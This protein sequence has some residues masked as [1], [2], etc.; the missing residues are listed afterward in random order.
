M[1]VYIASDHGG[2]ELKKFLIDELKRL[3]YSIDDLGPGNYDP[4]DDYPEYA[5]KV[6]EAVSTEQNSKMGIVLCRNGVG[7]CMVANKFKGVKCALSWNPEHIKSA[8]N[9]DNANVLAL[10]ADYIDNEA[11]LQIALAFLETP[12]SNEERHV[13][14]LKQVDDYDNTGNF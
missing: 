3:G 1:I 6:A 11:A 4:N 2:F 7:V 10:P 12:F 9:D 13:R 5:K 14:R 8:R